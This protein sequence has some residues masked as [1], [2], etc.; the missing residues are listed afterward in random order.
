VALMVP[1][2]RLAMQLRQWQTA[3]PQVEHIFDY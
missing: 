2:N 3:G 1:V